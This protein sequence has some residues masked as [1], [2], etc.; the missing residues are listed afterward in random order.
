[1]GI[2]RPSSSPVGAG[3]FFIGKRD[4]GLHPCIDYQALNTITE[5]NKYPL[6][7]INALF[8]PLQATTMFSKLDLHN[9]V[10]WDLLNHCVYVYIDDIL[11]LSRNLEEH[12]KHVWAVL[13]RLWEN[14]LFVKAEKC[15][16]HMSSVPFLGYME[17]GHGEG[18]AQAGS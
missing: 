18:T 12:W 11:I 16:F 7:L 13:Q 14:H 1:M 4:G 6:P 10:L 5:N 3:F 15:T 9:N 8:E 17:K 2:I